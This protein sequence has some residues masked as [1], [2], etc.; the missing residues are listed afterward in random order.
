VSI[1][2]NE[3]RSNQWSF[4]L[5]RLDPKDQSLWTMNRRVIRIATSSPPLVTTRRLALSD[6]E[7]AEALA[8]SLEAQLQPVNDPWSRLSLRWLIRQCEHALLLPQTSLK[9]PTPRRFKTPFEV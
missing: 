8:D 7:K 1:P 9:Y 5:E 6:S 4:A 2:L 3:W